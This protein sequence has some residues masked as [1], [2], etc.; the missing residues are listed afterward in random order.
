MKARTNT[1]RSHNGAGLALILCFGLLL[2]T[3]CCSDERTAS[4][5][6]GTHSAS[7]MVRGLADFHGTVALQN[8]TGSCAV[9]HGEDYNGGQVGVSCID[10]HLTSGACIACH[11]GLDNHTGAPP[12]G[13]RS[14]ISD[15][16]VAVGAHT[17]HLTGTSRSAAVTCQSC[18]LV[19]ASMFEPYHLNAN[20]GVLDSIA[21]ITWQGFADGGRARWNRTARTCSRTY[22]HGNFSGGDST[23]SPIWTSPKPDSLRCGTCHNSGDNPDSLGFIHIVHYSGNTFVCADCHSGVVDSSLHI[24]TPSLHVNGVANVTPLD[25]TRCDQCHG[26]GPAACTHCH[27]GGDNQTGA[28]PRGLHGENSAAELAVGAHTPH[29]ESGYV[30]DAFACNE[31]H[32]VPSRLSDPDHWAVDSVAEIT[33]GSL[34]GTGSTWSRIT[35]R[36]S[37]T[38][39][40]GNFYGGY[41]AN[42]PIWNA[43]GQAAC[44]SCHDDGANPG[45]LLGKHSK[46]V[47]SEHIGCYECHSTTVDSSLSIIGKAV[48]VDGQN[49]VA[50]GARQITYSNGGCSGSGLCHGDE[51]WF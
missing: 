5:L 43:P 6:P 14:E 16:T 36:C 27:G 15:T 31:C 28:P 21:E 30:A 2:S 46:H 19:P 37:Y 22:C 18:H 40:H 1:G 32:K 42:A 44:G 35:R 41:I 10:C 4:Q 33:W 8:G 29:M 25:T 20:G 23:Y 13:L 3:W 39:C 9:C 17:L 49:T 48:H 12:L 24:I 34:A 11:G 7:W 50:F 38:Y 45:D 51:N 26:T 47:R